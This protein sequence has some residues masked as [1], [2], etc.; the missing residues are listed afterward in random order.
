MH[1]LYEAVSMKSNN[2][3]LS[4]F[5]ILDLK[6]KNEI[7]EMLGYSQTK[8]YDNQYTYFRKFYATRTPNK[9]YGR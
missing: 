1:S 6:T 8:I 3:Y 4:K 5:V 2:H 7:K 9:I